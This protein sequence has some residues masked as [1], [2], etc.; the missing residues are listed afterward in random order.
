MDPPNTSSDDI[1]MSENSPTLA[2][3]ASSAPQAT[4]R[5]LSSSFEPLY[6]TSAPA[7]ANLESRLKDTFKMVSKLWIQ[8]IPSEETIAFFANLLARE[9]YVHSEVGDSEAR[10]METSAKAVCRSLFTNAGNEGFPTLPADVS[11]TDAYV[12]LIIEFFEAVDENC[13]PHVVETIYDVIKTWESDPD[14]PRTVRFAVIVALCHLYNSSADGSWLDEVGEACTALCRLFALNLDSPYL[15]FIEYICNKTV[16]K[17]G[18]D[19]EDGRGCLFDFLEHLRDC[20]D[21]RTKVCA[22]LF[23]CVYRIVD[24]KFRERFHREIF[25]T[26]ELDEGDFLPSIYPAIV[27]LYELYLFSD[28]QDRHIWWGGLKRTG[29]CFYDILASVAPWKPEFDDFLDIFEYIASAIGHDE[30]GRALL[31]QFAENVHGMLDTKLYSEQQTNRINGVV[32]KMQDA[33]A[34]GMQVVEVTGAMENNNTSIRYLPWSDYRLAKIDEDLDSFEYRIDAYLKVMQE[35]W[36]DDVANDTLPDS[37]V[38]LFAQIMAC[39]VYRHD[40]SGHKDEEG[41]SPVRSAAEIIMTGSAPI[42]SKEGTGIGWARTSARLYRRLFEVVDER[43]KSEMYE[44]IACNFKESDTEQP[45][46]RE[47]VI[48]YILED[49]STKVLNY[50]SRDQRRP[51]AHKYYK[52]GGLDWFEYIV[53]T[54]GKKMAREAKGC[55]ML[56]A[57]AEGFNKLSKKM[58]CLG[59]E[60]NRILALEKVMLFAAAQV[61]TES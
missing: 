46:F 56:N 8:A 43:F 32:N 39:D 19:E 23:R 38:T 59:E 21:Y 58:S 24:A 44:E 17:M 5:C 49:A 1:P 60:K 33:S 15:D 26:M 10:N 22:R 20:S 18:Q 50:M 28:E 34:E 45:W 30:D 11:L 31:R 57:F 3:A 16:E 29:V 12:H 54:I 52:E 2:N 35:I 14:G 13:A 37:S 61:K 4:N 53:P 48:L 7:I 25:F 51:L 55:D 41:E 27:M 9:V 42:E 40:I 47:I 36:A 6:S